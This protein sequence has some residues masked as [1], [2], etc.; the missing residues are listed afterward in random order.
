MLAQM[1]NEMFHK[2]PNK[3]ASSYIF[4]VISLGAMVREWDVE[5]LMPPLCSDRLHVIHLT[6][7]TM[8]GARLIK[9][10]TKTTATG[11]I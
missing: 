1:E 6:Y 4:Q 3:S 5:L 9:V 7:A 10:A 11:Y 2:R 8:A